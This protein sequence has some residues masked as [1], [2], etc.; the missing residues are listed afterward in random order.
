MISFLRYQDSVFP[1]RPYSIILQKEWPITY[2]EFEQQEIDTFDYSF[3]IRIDL[4]QITYGNLI[5]NFF[6]DIDSASFSMKGSWRSYDVPDGFYGSQ[7]SARILFSGLRFVIEPGDSIHVVVNYDKS[8][9][10]DRVAVNFS[11]PGGANN[12]FLR[13]RD[14]FDLYNKSF[15]LP[16]D[17]GLSNEDLIM[18][19]DLNSLNKAKDTLSDGYYTL[20]KKDIRFENLKMKHALIRASL[21][22]SEID[23]D[24]KRAIAREYYSYLDTLTLRPDYLN[25]S[26]FRSYIDFHLEYLNRIITGKDI[27][28]G[29]NEKSYWLAKAVFDAEILKTF[30]YERLT[31]QMETPI[32]FNSE[33]YQYMDL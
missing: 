17:E 13:S 25:S 12:N 3:K 22:G 18:K 33:K 30:L 14:R 32:F 29:N 6:P 28:Y 5:V 16:L 8:N 4:N 21:Y 19:E 26:V 15:K 31:F 9:P 24:E 23:I 10:Y 27:P 20:L 11:G 2:Q 1:L 7:Y